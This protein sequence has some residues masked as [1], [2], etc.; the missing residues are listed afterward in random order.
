MT[1]VLQAR[2]DVFFIASVYIVNVYKT[3]IFFFFD[4]KT[5]IYNIIIQR[6]NE[7]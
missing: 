1:Y 6:T 3:H 5:H 4:L 7:N 2:I